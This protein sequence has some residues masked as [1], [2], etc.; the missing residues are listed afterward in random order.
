MRIVFFKDW[1]DYSCFKNARENSQVRKRVKELA[2]IGD[3]ICEQRLS[4]IIGI[5]LALL[6][7]NSFITF[8][9]SSGEESA[10]KILDSTEFFI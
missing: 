2:R 7:D 4:I 5:S 8:L 6:E 10:R 1:A 9:I 3:I